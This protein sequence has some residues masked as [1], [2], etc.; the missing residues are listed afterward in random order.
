[1]TEIQEFVLCEHACDP[2]ECLECSETP[3]PDVQRWADA[4]LHDVYGT[5][6]LPPAL[7]GVPLS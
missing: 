2:D 5:G 1:M 7:V 3:V 4:F 6:E